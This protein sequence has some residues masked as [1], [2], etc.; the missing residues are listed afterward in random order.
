MQ[1]KEYGFVQMDVAELPKEHLPVA[2]VIDTSMSTT[3]IRGLMQKC[4]LH[5]V[6]NFRED[7][8]MGSMVELLV[9]YYND[10][11]ETAADFVPLS[12]ISPDTLKF[13][14]SQGCTNTGAALLHA[15]E[16]L[17][18]KK[19]EWKKNRERYHQP[20]CFLLTDGYPDAGLHA[21]AEE[22]LRVEQQYKAAARAIRQREQE[23][24]LVFFAAGIQQRESQHSAS[25]KR[26]RELTQYPN[27]VIP[28]SNDLADT[29]RFEDFFSLI[30][31]STN[32]IFECTPIDA[33][34]E[35]MW[36]IGPDRNSMRR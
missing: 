18:E 1:K 31:Y 29:V 15:L 3:R 20:L 12:K 13:P 23:K 34:L 14:P 5:L 36:A 33:V 35:D 32:A 28:V 27:R 17:D 22:K 11:Y 8:I 2:L 9:V 19:Q 24:K 7:L 30:E 6:N 16:R 26:L 25:I 21:T 10:N 4:I